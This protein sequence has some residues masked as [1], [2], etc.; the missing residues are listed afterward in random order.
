MIITTPKMWTT[1]N[2]EDFHYADRLARSKDAQLDFVFYNGSEQRLGCRPP[3]DDFWRDIMQHIGRWSSASMSLL[4]GQSLSPLETAKAPRLRTL[5]LTARSTSSETHVLNLFKGVTPVL[6]DLQLS[7][8]ALR[9]W[10][11]PS[12]HGL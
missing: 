3:A 4:R 10:M 9:S 7:G 11:T 6:Q 2:A 1:I 5:Y 12:P 8:I